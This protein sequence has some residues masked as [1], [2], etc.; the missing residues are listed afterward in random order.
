VSVRLAIEL[1]LLLSRFPSWLRCVLTANCGARAELADEIPAREAAFST[2]QRGSL[3]K[4]PQR[5]L[6]YWPLTGNPVEVILSALGEDELRHPGRFRR[7]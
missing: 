4:W 3:F 5:S 1:T 7:E 2:P 6:F